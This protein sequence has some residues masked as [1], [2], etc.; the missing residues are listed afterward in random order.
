[1]RPLFSAETRRRQQENDPKWHVKAILQAICT[2][3]AFI[4]L[5]LFAAATAITNKYYDSPH[6][7]WSDW[8]PLFPVR[9]HPS[10]A[11]RAFGAQHPALPAIF[12]N[13]QL[14]LR[15]IPGPHF[16]NIQPR[17]LF[18]S[19]TSPRQTH[20]SGLGCRLPPPHLG[21][22]CPLYRPLRRLGLVLVVAARALPIQQRLHP[23]LRL[24]FLVRAM[25]TSNLHRRQTRN[26][27]KR[28]PGT[29]DVSPSATNLRPH[30]FPQSI[31]D[32]DDE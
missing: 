20:S 1:M 19:S 10:S 13:L 9:S 7:D 2:F 17:L 24:E 12:L 3:L 22:G 15:P 31:D 6:G 26:R 14:I 11:K 32:D 5:I 8:M 28:F 29:V 18:P 16:I 27:S 30:T 21:A 23:L 4:A 25:P